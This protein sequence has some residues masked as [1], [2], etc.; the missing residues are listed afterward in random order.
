MINDCTLP[1]TVQAIHYFIVFINFYHNYAPYFEIRLKP[2]RKLYRDLFQKPIPLTAWTSKPKD[3]LLD[4]KTSIT[5]YPV[6][7]R[8]YLDKLTFLK[9]YWSVDNMA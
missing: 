1:S 7:S 9:T 2:L 8:N 5:Y 4:L 6:L 3:L